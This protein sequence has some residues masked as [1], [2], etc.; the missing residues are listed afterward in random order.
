MADENMGFETR[1]LTEEQKKQ[2]KEAMDKFADT[3][4]EKKILAQAREMKNQKREQDREDVINYIKTID[5]SSYARIL[6]N[7]KVSEAIW[8]SLTMDDAITKA[9]YEDQVNRLYKIYTDHVQVQQQRAEITEKANRG[10]NLTRSE[11]RILKTK[12]KLV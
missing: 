9:R 4:D 8:S 3:R 11:H 5:K 10:A 6:N 1:E 12:T 7:D 2:I